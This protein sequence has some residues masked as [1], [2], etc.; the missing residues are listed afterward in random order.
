MSPQN[1]CLLLILITISLF[2]IGFIIL[3]TLDT[4]PIPQI[5]LQNI[6]SFFDWLF[7]FF[8]LFWCTNFKFWWNPINQILLLILELLVSYWRRIC[9]TQSHTV[10]PTFYDSKVYSI[11]SYIYVYNLFWVNFCIKCEEWGPT[12]F[13]VGG[14]P[15]VWTKFM[16]KS[17]VSLL[18]CLDTLVKNQLIVNMEGFFFPR[19]YTPLIYMCTPIPV[20][21]YI[22]WTFSLCMLHILLFI[23]IFF[24]LDV[25]DN[26]A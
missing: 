4:I 22:I 16:G 15:V 21:Y 7:T 11:S 3:W 13:F 6:S 9:L 12:L 8:M 17:N 10:N 14:Y 19:N 20:L 2:I 25:L 23:S 18:N 24:M 26:I 1:F 5:G